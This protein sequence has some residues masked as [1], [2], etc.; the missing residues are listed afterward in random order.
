MTYEK[1]L[2]EALE[3]LRKHIAPQG[4]FLF[5]DK[6]KADSNT[7]EHYLYK[8]L[9]ESGIEEHFW[10]PMVYYLKE[11]GY[12]DLA[13][14][15]P[16]DEIKKRPPNQLKITLNGLIF[17]SNGGYVKK[18]ESFIAAEKIKNSRENRLSTGTV[19]LAIGTFLLVFVEVLIHWNELRH[20]FSC[21]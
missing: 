9:K 11:D 3:Y 12:I 2:N 4:T 21:R 7:Q 10:L 17:I 6:T 19:L 15:P 13:Y 8:H 18:K 14:D 16:E 1:Q 5:Y 20:L